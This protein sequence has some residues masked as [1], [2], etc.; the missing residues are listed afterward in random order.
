MIEDVLKTYDEDEYIDLDQDVLKA[1]WRRRCLLKTYEY[2]EFIRLDQ[3][4]LKTSSESED[5]RPLQDFFTT[6]SSRCVFAR[7][8]QIFAVFSN[9]YDKYIE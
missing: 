4:V 3:D 8:F 1:S 7:I 6:S 2:G 5:E 9:I